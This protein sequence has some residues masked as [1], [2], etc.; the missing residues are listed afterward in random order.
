[1]NRKLTEVFIQ[2]EINDRL[3]LI[4]IHFYIKLKQ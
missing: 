4:E 3:L 2:Y 1:M